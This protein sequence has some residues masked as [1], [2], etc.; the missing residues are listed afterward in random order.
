VQ[1]QNTF[2]IS[3]PFDLGSLNPAMMAST[4]PYTVFYE[5]CGGTIVRAT[6]A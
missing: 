1:T 5:T 4:C 6:D 2:A 3:F